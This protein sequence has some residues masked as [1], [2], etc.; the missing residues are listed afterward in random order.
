MGNKY[1]PPGCRWE[2]ATA[3]GIGF[4]G[5]WSRTSAIRYDICYGHLP[6]LEDDLDHVPTQPTDEEVK[7]WETAEGVRLALLS[8]EDAEEE[9]RKLKRFGAK[10]V[11]WYRAKYLNTSKEAESVVASALD[12]AA[13]DDKPRRRQVMQLFTSLHIDEV[14]DEVTA[15]FNA[16]C[17]AATQARAEALK[18][19]PNVKPAKVEHLTYQHAIMKAR[20]EAISPAEKEHLKTLIEEKYQEE[21]KEWETMRKTEP[22]KYT[23]YAKEPRLCKAVLIRFT[24]SSRWL[25][26]F[27]F[28]DQMKKGNYKSTGKAFATGLT[29]PDAAPEAYNAVE[30]SMIAFANLCYSGSTI[31]DSTTIAMATRAVQ[32]AQSIPSPTSTV[33]TAPKRTSS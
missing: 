16:A 31:A 13:A 5:K 15:A 12:A 3:A 32:P 21:L 4:I 27:Y 9:R 6:N 29:W 33:S 25:V 7:V 22:E 30:Q 1:L 23:H 11:A 28:A 26:R 8:K 2:N 19:D 18:T 24:T 14:R 17:N 10:I 20:Y